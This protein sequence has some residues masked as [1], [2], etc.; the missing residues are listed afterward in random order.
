VLGFTKC[1][2]QTQTGI[3]DSFVRRQKPCCLSDLRSIQLFDKS[4]SSQR[5]CTDKDVA[6]TSSAV[7]SHPTPSNCVSKKCIKKASSV[8]RQYHGRFPKFTLQRKYE[9]KTT[10]SGMYRLHV[11]SSIIVQYTYLLR[12]V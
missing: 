6:H 2:V 12:V 1:D 7:K 11:G 3:V 5:T 9:H 4:E 10:S 8:K